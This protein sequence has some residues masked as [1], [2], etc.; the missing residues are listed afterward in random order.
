MQGDR[1]YLEIQGSKVRI[2]EPWDFSNVDFTV[3]QD[4][5]YFYRDLAFG[6]NK[7]EL[8]F[9]NGR[10][11][12]VLDLLIQEARTNGSNAEVYFHYND[13]IRMRLDFSKSESNYYDYF[14]CDAYNDTVLEI[15]KDNKDV[16]VD[17]LSDKDIFEQPANKLQLRRT[18]ASSM[19]IN[20][21]SNWRNDTNN[22]ISNNNSTLRYLTLNTIGKINKSDIK[23]TYV[24]YVGGLSNFNVNKGL[25][26]NYQLL[27]LKDNYNE[28]DIDINLDMLLNFIG[29]PNEYNY[30]LNLYYGSN[31]LNGDEWFNNLTKVNIKTV[32]YSIDN[33]YIKESK[34]IKIKNIIRSNGIWLCWEVNG[35]RGTNEFGINIRDNRSEVN[36]KGTSYS[37]GSVINALPYKDCINN[38]LSKIVP[39]TTCRFNVDSDLQSNN[40]LFSGNQIRFGEDKPFILTWKDVTEQLKEFGLGY[41]LEGNVVV[42][43]NIESFYK[44]ELVHHF[45]NVNSYDS[46]KVI[47]DDTYSVNIL[48]YGYKKYQA[49]KD[50]SIEGNAGTTNGE[51]QWYIQNKFTDSTLKIDLPISRDKFM[52]EDTRI[53]ALVYNEN[54]STNDDSTLY[55]FNKNIGSIYVEETAFLRA[56]FQEDTSTQSFSVR[57]SEFSWLKIGTQLNGL[58]NFIINGVTR[59]YLIRDISDNNIVC[60]RINHSE[61]LNQDSSFN[62]EFNSN[63]DYNIDI[64]NAN[65]IRSIRQNIANMRAFLNPYNYYTNAPITSREYKEDANFT[66][67]GITETDPIYFYEQFKLTPKV[68]EFKTTDRFDVY[69]IIE[70]NINGYCTV[71]DL[72]GK[73]IRFYIKELNLRVLECGN[74]EYEIKGQIYDTVL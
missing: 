8:M 42:F 52:L 56:T 53:K 47:E 12:N 36:I 73:L 48:E 60:I 74:A 68:V 30:E 21:T 1:F 66:L 61:I 27:L 63:T 26:K 31:D 22:N 10:H 51:S 54:T 6:G 23:D 71:Y 7:A 45:N 49:L 59:E 50:N 70:K 14:R 72:K 15:L 69:K 20:R 37:Y 38:L 40:L 39:N 13:D 35:G 58:I 28:L 29:F 2:N 17:L 24:P 64:S 44:D 62:F 32:K 16:K 9:G 5:E 18:Y 43:D 11:D 19:G 67:N 55:L 65:N 33:I 57:D 46:F 3:I 25:I 34:K 41:R 4:K